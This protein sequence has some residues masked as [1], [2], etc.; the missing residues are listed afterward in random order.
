VRELAVIGQEDDKW[1]ET[2]HAVLVRARADLSEQE[3]LDHCQGELSRY[4]QPRVVRFGDELSR[5]ASGKVLKRE[6][7]LKFK[8]ERGV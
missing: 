8:N 2:V 4:K 6:L 1:G 3:I 5:N 7:K